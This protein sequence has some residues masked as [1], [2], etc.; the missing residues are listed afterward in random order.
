MG[1]LFDDQRFAVHFGNLFGHGGHHPYLHAHL[2][3][4]RNAIR[5]GPLAI[6]H[7]HVDQLRI[8]I[9]YTPGRYR[10]ICGLRHWRDISGA[11]HAHH[12][13][14]L[15]RIGYD[16]IGSD[17]RSLFFIVVAARF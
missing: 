7:S 17:L 13:A 8:G 6:W 2:F 3:A 11:S 15:Q 10:S 4:Y 1:H 9:E 16:F 5:Y 14:L 12:W